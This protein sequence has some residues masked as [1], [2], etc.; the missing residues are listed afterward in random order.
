[1]NT[2]NQ[3]K[4][5]ETV[6]KDGTIVLVYCPNFRMNTTGHLHFAS[7]LPN[8]VRIGSMFDFDLKEHELPTHW[9]EC[10]ELPKK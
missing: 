9:I 4:P 8:C 3:W 5:I 7:Y 10:P 6:P 1:M 2:N